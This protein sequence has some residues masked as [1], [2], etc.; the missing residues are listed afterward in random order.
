MQK[1]WSIVKLLAAAAALAPSS[2]C[3][4]QNQ[5]QQFTNV[6]IRVIRQ[7]FFQKS[8]RVE[9]GANLAAV[10]N[11]AYTYTYLPSAKLGLHM[12][13]WLEI[14]GE[15]A[16]GIT[17]NKSDCTE[18]GGK[19]SIEPIVDEFDNMI[20]GG[21]ALTPIYGKYQIASGDVVYFDWF[22]IAGGGLANMKQREQGCKPR[23]PDEPVKLPIPYSP[24]QFNFGMGQRFFL[25]KS[26]AL[27]WYLRDYVVGNK[28]GA[29][30][31]SVMLSFGASYYL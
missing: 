3:F 15:G 2:M 5:D 6:E 12:T 31:Q 27:N 16:V 18:L 10:M 23:A 14:F 26:A 1:G 22:L 11:K 13:E 25:N 4:A 28:A 7:K 20:G 8:V 30:G 29:L 19:F 17:I 21:V 24:V 9:L